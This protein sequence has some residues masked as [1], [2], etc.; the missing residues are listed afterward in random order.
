MSVEP[1]FDRKSQVKE[2][3]ILS[4]KGGTGKTS[5]TASLAVLASPCVVADGDVDAADLHLVLDPEVKRR[6]DFRGGHEAVIMKQICSGCGACKSYCRFDAIEEIARPDGGFIYRVDEISCEGCGVCVSICP[7]S[8]IEFPTRLSGEWMVS[9]TRVGPMVHARLGI[10]AENSGK[11]V[12][13]VRREAMSIAKAQSLPLV[14]VDGPPGIGCPVIASVTGA[15]QLLVVAEP[16]VSGEHDLNRVLDLAKHFGVPAAI[17][18]NRWDIHPEAAQR[19]EE[20]AAGKGAE[21]LHRIR[22]DPSVTQAQI[23]ARTV[24]EQ[25]GGAADDIRA[26][27]QQLEELL[28]L[29]PDSP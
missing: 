1:S 7:I 2:L 4:G 17:S 15:S 28:G 19:I 24:A 3:V 12:S 20:G 27:W 9:D 13:V 6:E 22:Y 23:A 25:G 29:V 5:I 11:L 18:V 26:L 8:A 14:L 21:V 16:T 10:A